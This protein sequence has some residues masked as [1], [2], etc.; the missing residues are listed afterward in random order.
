MHFVKSPCTHSMLCVSIGNFN[1]L[2]PR[3]HTIIEKTN[4]H[5][6]MVQTIM[7]CTCNAHQIGKS[8]LR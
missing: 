8:K 3:S 7:L 6:E 1:Q 5:L 4:T 2:S